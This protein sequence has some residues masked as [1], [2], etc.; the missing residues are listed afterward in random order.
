MYR[1]HRSCELHSGSFGASTNLPFLERKNLIPQPFWWL[2]KLRIELNFA[3]RKNISL[4]DN[5]RIFRCG[6]SDVR[7]YK[8]IFSPVTLKPHSLAGLENRGNYTSFN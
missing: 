7:E 8:A 2:R 3:P 6:F 5:E 1:K 4:A